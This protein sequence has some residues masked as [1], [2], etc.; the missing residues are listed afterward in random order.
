MCGRALCG[1]APQSYLSKGASQIS[2]MEG[3]FRMKLDLPAN[4]GSDDLLVLHELSRALRHELPVED[5]DLNT[6]EK[7]AVRALGA[8]VDGTSVLRGAQGQPVQLAPEDRT[9]LEIVLAIDDVGK[10]TGTDGCHA[11]AGYRLFNRHHVVLRD[12]IHRHCHEHGVVPSLVEDDHLRMILWLVRHHEV[13]EELFRGERLAVCLDQITLSWRKN[14]DDCGGVGKSC[15]KC[16]KKI[17]RAVRFLLILSTCNALAHLPEDAVHNRVQFWRKVVAWKDRTRFANLAHRLGQWTH[18]ET[19]AHVAGL[20]GQPGDVDQLSSDLNSAARDVFGCRVDRIIHGTELLQALGLRWKAKLLNTIANHYSH[21]F[22]G[23]TV[24]LLFARPYDPEDP[25][26]AGTLARY[27][28]AIRNGQLTTSVNYD[29]RE[30]C[31]AC[32]VGRL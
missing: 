32:P 8:M 29:N 12:A 25:Q 13:L 20:L 26:A 14:C 1:K 21:N 19:Q 22:D 11:E 17:A 7:A 3:G 5:V 4:V 15:P 16:E 10:R 6:R 2:P 30:I 24:T 27:E 18:T 9:L 31:V 28:E 23:E